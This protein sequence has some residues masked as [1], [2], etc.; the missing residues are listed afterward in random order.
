M[1]CR[2]FPSHVRAAAL[3]AGGLAVGVLAGTLACSSPGVQYDYDAQADFSGYRSF[4]WQA[5]PQGGARAGSLDNAIMDER[6]RRAVVA[7]LVAKGF[8]HDP[9]GDPD[10]RVRYHPEREPDRSHKV[11]LGL[12]LGLGPVGVGVG[13]PVGDAHREAVAG[14]ALEIHD[15]RTHALV[16]KATAPGVLRGWDSPAETDGEVAD[17]VKALLRRFPPRR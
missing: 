9:G 4:D 1:V 10:F 8:R 13:A 6:V 14:L 5:R 11:H 2:P 16:W 7:A 17:A 12:G 3:V 15:A